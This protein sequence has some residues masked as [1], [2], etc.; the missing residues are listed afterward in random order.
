MIRYI[1]LALAVYVVYRLVFD[2]IVPVFR[3][4]RQVHRQFKDIHQKMQDQANATQNTNPP[5]GRQ[6][7]QQKQTAAGDYIDFEEVK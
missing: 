4:S 1:L 6:A 3:A 2:L 7:P 5:N